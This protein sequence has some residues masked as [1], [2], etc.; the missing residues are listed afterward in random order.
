MRREEQQFIVVQ[1][2]GV[3]LV[4]LLSS[5]I[6]PNDSVD[7]DAGLAAC[8]QYSAESHPR[9]CKYC[10]GGVSASET[11]EANMLC[12]THLAVRIFSQYVEEV[13]RPQKRT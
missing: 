6:G 2:D 10:C 13:I 3:A 1:L 12:G 11:D 9:G 4:S 5:H 8:R 7:S